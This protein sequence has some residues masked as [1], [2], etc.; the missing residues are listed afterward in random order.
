[1]AG[2][3]ISIFCGDPT[4]SILLK[5]SKNSLELSGNVAASSLSHPT[6]IISAPILSAYD[7]AIDVNTIFLPGTQTLLAVSSHMSKS[8]NS[9]W[10]KVGISLSLVSDELLILL[11]Q[12]KSITSWVKPIF[13]Q[14][15]LDAFNS[16]LKLF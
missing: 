14:I 1:M 15:S 16:C 12:G 9:S 13:L 11:S 4:F 7:V 3:L 5:L 6:I 2:A 8:S 10:V